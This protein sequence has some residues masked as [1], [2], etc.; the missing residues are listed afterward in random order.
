MSHIIF[1]HGVGNGAACRLPPPPL[2]GCEPS[3]QTCCAPCR[4]APCK[5]RLRDARTMLPREVERG[6][7]LT[8]FGCRGETMPLVVDRVG[9]VLRRRGACHEIACLAPSRIS[10]DGV[11]F[12]RWPDA[13]LSAPAGQYE[14]DL[15]LN[16]CEVGSVLL[17]KPEPV[18]GIGG[19]EVVQ[20]DFGCV[21][22]ECSSCGCGPA[23]CVCGVA[24]GDFAEPDGYPEDAIHSCGGCSIC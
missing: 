18:V 10:L 13:F 12:F 8:E 9:L 21:A 16:R 23:Q 5:T 4:I 6:F 7:T 19:D 17:V 2:D 20:A 3:C 14:G 24:C 15:I 11:V 1:G 22:D